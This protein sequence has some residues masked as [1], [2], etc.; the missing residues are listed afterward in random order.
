[1]RIRRILTHLNNVGFRRYAIEFVN[2]LETEIYGEV[3]GFEKFL[4]RQ[5]TG[6]MQTA[7]LKEL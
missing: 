1:L 7:P 5:M 3:G 6:K 2:F 4:N